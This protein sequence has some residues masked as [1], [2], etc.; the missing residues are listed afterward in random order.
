MKDIARILLEI[1]AVTLSP[2]EPYIWASGIRS[3]I[4]CDNRLLLSY[5]K[6]WKTVIQAMIEMVQREFPQVECIMGTAAAGIPHASVCSYEMNLPGGFVRTASK[7]HGKGNQ[8]EGKVTPGMK[9]VVI[10]DLISTGG[11][12]MAAVNVLKESGCE[13]LGIISIFSYGMDRARSAMEKEGIRCI[14]L[15]DYPE[16]LSLAVQF[17]YLAEHDVEKLIRFMQDPSDE[18][19][20][21]S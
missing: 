10:E 12:S 9:T 11:S 13:V 1:K 16:L 21:N 8:I 4:Y 20:M 15:T 14:S 7:D 2:K 6:E 5:P 3:P 18:T 17:G 19:W